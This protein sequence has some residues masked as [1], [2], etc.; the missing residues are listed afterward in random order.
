MT[1]SMINVAQIGVGYWGPN[2]LRNFAGNENCKVQV[3]ADIASERRA[4]V[5]GLYPGVQTTDRVSDV[6]TDSA[7]DAVVIATPVASHFD[8]ATEALRHGKHV[9]VEKPM[10]GSVDEVEELARLAQD[11]GLTAMVGHTFLYNPAVRCLKRLVD[12]RCLGDI[13]YIYSRRLN[14]GRVRSDVDAMWNLAPHDI[15]I[16]QY[17][18]GDPIPKAVT[19]Q[20]QSYIQNGIDDVAFMHVE[21]PDGIMAHVHVSWLDPHK[22]RTM[23]LVGTEKMIVYDDIADN[24]IAVYDKGVEPKAILGERMDFD[25]AEFRSFDYRSGD[26]EFPEIDWTEPLALEVAHFL[27]CIRDGIPCLTG[28]EHAKRVVE[29]L[30]MADRSQ[31]SNGIETL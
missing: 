22:V 1:R 26:V 24:K 28:P 2:L 13:R 18:L 12:E 11:G 16:I 25:S 5:E 27:E 8:L 7:V 10:A 20:G 30:E 29:I 3:V 14:L 15:S 23:T 9:L 17:L 6:L 19:K 4:F 31:R 21:Y